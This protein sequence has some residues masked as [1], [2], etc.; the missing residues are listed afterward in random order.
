M[1]DGV[2]DGVPLRLGVLDQAPIAEG[3]TGADALRHSLDLARLA[4][5]L[6]YQR[7]WVAEHHASPM[8]AGASPEALIG[9][10]A[11][12]TARIRVGSGGVM[13]PHYSPLKVAETFSMLSALYPDRID[14]GLGRAPG[15]DPATA[16]ALQRDRRAMAPD[17]FPEQLAEL[18]GHFAGDLPATH[19]FRRYAALLPGRPHVPEPWLLG[20]SP[21]S[22]I[23]AAELGLPYAFADFISPTGAAVAARYRET[24]RPS[25]W[26]ERPHVAVGVWALCAE[27]DAEAQ[28]LAASYRMVRA[29][30][31]RGRF[32]PVPPVETAQAFLA[33]E[34]ESPRALPVGR[35][36][37]VG[38]PAAVR[39][40][41]EAIA[42]EYAADE[43]L[44]VT[45]THDH[46]ARKRSY[47]LV[48][49]AFALTAGEAP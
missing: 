11:Q 10:I 6:G 24:F 31:L 34:G 36:A 43:V 7:Y 18:L 25:R 37:V 29:L 5:R 46:A 30:F 47:E 33:A 22:G 17:D 4:D 26:Q 27:T 39:A 35:R 44:L 3:S 40:G 48:A 45:I 12:V 19:P 20:S 8:L 28:R 21:Q 14:L 16:F 13:L 32:I 2:S 42:R 41:I 49:D 15:S 9:P 38:D 1:S 23:W